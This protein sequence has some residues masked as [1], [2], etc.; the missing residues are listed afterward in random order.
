MIF[1][2]LY[3]KIRSEPW[4]IQVIWA[5][6][7]FEFI[8]ALVEQQW[9][10]AGVAL[11]TFCLT[12]VPLY[13]SSRVGISFPT[14]LMVAVTAFIFATIFLGEA[15]DYY[16]RFW[17]W[18]ILLH[19]GSAL[20]FGL[21]GFMLVFMLFEG[22]RYAAPR[23]AMALIA[24]SFAVTIGACWEIFEYAMDQL[25][26]TN[27]QKSGLDDTMG[28]LMVDVV[29]GSVGAFLG[30]LYMIGRGPGFTRGLF[31]DFVSRNRR[32]FKKFKRSK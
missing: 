15:F 14:P 29:G 7:S 11:F 12:L 17:W 16:N 6:L 23:W 18:D 30:W 2:N 9:P 27:M 32:F 4:P 21:V 22:D 24:F 28:D 25:F 31:E 13:V 20:G 10:L 1:K 8:L 26:G 3:R 5:V 19:G